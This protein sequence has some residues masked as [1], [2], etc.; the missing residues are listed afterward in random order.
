MADLQLKIT[1]GDIDVNIQGEGE[2]VYKI[3]KELREE[4]LGALHKVHL[5]SG[6]GTLKA[7]AEHLSDETKAEGEKAS[8]QTSKPKKKSNQ[9]VNAAHPA[10]NRRLHFSGFQEFDFPARLNP[11]R[12]RNPPCN[13]PH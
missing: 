2:L 7:S 13:L 10:F 8:V 4:G 9:K 6:T 11:H 3:F 12:R 1:M 5:S